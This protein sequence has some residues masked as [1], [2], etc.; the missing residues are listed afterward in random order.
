MAVA[1]ATGG[2]YYPA[3]SADELNDGLRRTCRPT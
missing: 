3:E 2:E 1:E